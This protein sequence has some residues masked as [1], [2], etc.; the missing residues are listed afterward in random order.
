MLRVLGDYFV[1]RKQ[2]NEVRERHETVENVRNSP[3]RR[4]GHVRTDKHGKNVQRA[5]NHDC[6]FVFAAEVFKTP[7]AVVVPAQNCCER[8]EHKA[9]HQNK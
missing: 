5:V 8:K 4:Y 6:R 3:Y 1:E 9:Y 7:L 2:R